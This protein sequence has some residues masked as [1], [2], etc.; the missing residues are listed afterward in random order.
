MS[1]G[2]LTLF[3]FFI[4]QRL[5][6]FLCDVWFNILKILFTLFLVLFPWIMVYYILGGFSMICRRF[7]LAKLEKEILCYF[8]TRCSKI[9]WHAEKILTYLT[10]FVRGAQSIQSARV[11]WPVV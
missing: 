10:E 5:L 1:G 9:D 4:R 6:I 2:S 8:S 7:L 3:F 11:P